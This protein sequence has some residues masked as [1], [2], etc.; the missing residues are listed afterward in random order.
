MHVSMYMFKRMLIGVC[1]Y[2]RAFTYVYVPMNI[3]YTCRCIC[4]CICM[5][6]RTH[7]CMST[8]LSIYP[9]IYLASY[10]SIHRSI[11][12]P[13]YLHMFTH[14]HRH[15]R[16]H[17][18]GRMIRLRHWNDSPSAGRV[19]GWQKA[20]GYETTAGSLLVKVAS[21]QNVGDMS[22]NLHA[23]FRIHINVYSMLYDCDYVQMRP[24]H[25]SSLVSL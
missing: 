13:S 23:Y 20:S 10:L 12:L 21:G 22:I 4:L 17:C 15:L 1:V 8:Y 2:V 14:K 25:V 16:M 11:Y 7:L 9:S 19:L 18:I 3:H 6:K 24:F 5:H